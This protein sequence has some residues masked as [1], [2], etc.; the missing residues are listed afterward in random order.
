[1]TTPT[2]EAPV[3]SQQTQ[4]H[5]R[6]RVN[7]EVQCGECGILEDCPVAGEATATECYLQVCKQ[8]DSLL[9]ALASLAKFAE[10]HIRLNIKGKHL[11]LAAG[12]CEDLAER[13]RA[14]IA[15]AKL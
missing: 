12:Q 3:T 2:R 9:A 10:D 14:A 5:A 13:A 8:R 7:G 6:V 15:G 4:R 1:M 11:A